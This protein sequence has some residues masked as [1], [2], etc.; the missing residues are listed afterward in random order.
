MS[1]INRHIAVLSGSG[2]SQSLRGITSA[3]NMLG[4]SSLPDRTRGPKSVYQLEDLLVGSSLSTRSSPCVRV[5]YPTNYRALFSGAPSP[6]P[7]FPAWLFSLTRPVRPSFAD[8]LSES[9]GR[10]GKKGTL[11]LFRTWTRQQR[12]EVDLAVPSQC[13]STLPNPL[14]CGEAL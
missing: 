7:T 5:N 10:E 14:R 12:S 3:E 13:L 4:R 1:C 2:C 6:S 9:R 8:V 11:G